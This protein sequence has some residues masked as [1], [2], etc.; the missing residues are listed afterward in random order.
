[1][2]DTFLRPRMPPCIA[3]ANAG[4]ECE[5]CPSLSFHKAEVWCCQQ[6]WEHSRCKCSLRG[7]GGPPGAKKD[8]PEWFAEWEAR[9]GR[10]EVERKRSTASRPKKKAARFAAGSA[11]EEEKKEEKPVRKGPRYTMTASRPRTPSPSPPPR[12]AKE[13]KKKVVLRVGEGQLSSSSMAVGGQRVSAGDFVGTAWS[14]GP[15]KRAEVV[16]PHAGE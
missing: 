14:L 11:R 15:Q 13:A 4:L 6:C 7:L 9:K 12:R 1:M 10:G 5:Y 16:L 3:C 8:F 2:T